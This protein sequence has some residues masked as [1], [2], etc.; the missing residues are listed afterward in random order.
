MRTVAVGENEP[1]RSFHGPVRPCTRPLFPSSDGLE[2]RPEKTIQRRDNGGQVGKLAPSRTSHECCPL[3]L[4]PSVLR[5][6]AGQRERTFAWDRDASAR[7]RRRDCEPHR[8]TVE[9][10]GFGQAVDVEEV[11]HPAVREREPHHRLGLLSNRGLR[12]VSAD[13]RARDI[14]EAR[15]VQDFRRRHDGVSGTDINP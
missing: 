6:F 9:R 2:H 1:Y 7:E 4:L 13:A 11:L 3:N 8:L 5:E 12:P 14:E 10:S 15:I